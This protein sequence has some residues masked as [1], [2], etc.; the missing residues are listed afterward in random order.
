MKKKII[1][2]FCLFFCLHQ[3]IFSMD[4]QI[5]KNEIEILKINEEKDSIEKIET[6]MKKWSAKKN[7][8]N[9]GKDA[10]LPLID[11][12]KD[13]F[14]KYYA[15]RALGEIGDERAISPLSEI[16]MDTTCISR[17]YSALALGRIKSKKAIPVLI[18]ALEKDNNDTVKKD[19]RTALEEI[20]G[21]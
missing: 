18:K 10:V 9:I 4:E 17:R 3:F 11:A 5:I 2:L 6:H 13:E 20:N 7:L 14:A 19:V 21:H 12:L 1:I 8:V 16:L 15:I